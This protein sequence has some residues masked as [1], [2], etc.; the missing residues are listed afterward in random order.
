MKSRD[1]IVC[2]RSAWFARRTVRS[3]DWLYLIVTCLLK[4]EFSFFSIGS[5]Y[6]LV[7]GASD[8]GHGGSSAVTIRLVDS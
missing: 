8:G 6:A 2:G 4:D 1:D 5:C 3:A 7:R